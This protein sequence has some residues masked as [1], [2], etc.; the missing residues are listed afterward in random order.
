MKIVDF[1][2]AFLENITAETVFKLY[3]VLPLEIYNKWILKQP[4]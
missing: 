2:S 3:V 4:D 1:T